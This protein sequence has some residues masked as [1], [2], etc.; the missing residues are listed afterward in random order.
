MRHLSK[1]L[2]V[3]AAGA[4][5]SGCGDDS[6]GCPDGG[7]PDATV[8]QG[9]GGARDAASDGATTMLFGLSRGDNSYVVTRVTNVTDGC[10]VNPMDFVGLMVPANYNETTQVFSLGSMQGTPPAPS[11]GS[12]VVSSNMATLMRMNVEGPSTLCYWTHKGTN[13]FRLTNHDKFTIDAKR[14][15]SMF[16]AGCPTADKPAGDMCTSTWTMDLEKSTG[17]ADG[18]AG[19]G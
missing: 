4:V 2:I 1:L 6:E 18:G 12:G 13:A 5:A 10:K 15:L 7:C 17:A 16:A 8:T 11:L 3:A 19:G 9:D 14:D